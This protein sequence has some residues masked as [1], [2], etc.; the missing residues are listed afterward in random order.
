MK[1]LKVVLLSF[2]L[3][4]QSAYS[5]DR[6]DEMLMDDAEIKLN[7]LEQRENQNNTYLSDIHSIELRLRTLRE[8]ENV[9]I[10]V[11]S[12]AGSMLMLALV[13][14]GAKLHIPPGT[15][16]MVG[17]YI[18][19]KGLS[20]GVVRL[21]ATEVKK[22]TEKLRELTYRLGVTKRDIRKQANY[23]CSIFPN[24]NMCDY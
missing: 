24:H 15:R 21:N 1:M 11:Q 16:A 17:A 2:I 3:V 7:I 20:R 22:L 13:I 8:G 12:V 10:Q 18:T 14:G 4:I 9:Y 5:F 6:L 23:Y 19:V